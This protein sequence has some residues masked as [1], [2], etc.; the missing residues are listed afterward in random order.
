MKGYF[1]SLLVDPQVEYLEQE[2]CPLDHIVSILF[3]RPVGTQFVRFK[4]RIRASLEI[5]ETLVDSMIHSDLT[6]VEPD[7]DC[8]RML[9][10]TLTDL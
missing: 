1:A 10:K 9:C 4:P 7:V 5:V 2:I 3:E 8:A 6:V